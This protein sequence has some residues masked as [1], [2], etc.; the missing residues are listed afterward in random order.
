M[1]EFASARESLETAVK[2]DN[3]RPGF[4]QFLAQACLRLE[5]RT[6]ARA[7]LEELLRLTPPNYTL[8]IHVS[9]GTLCVDLED[10]TCAQRALAA[11]RRLKPD[12]GGVKQLEQH[13]EQRK[14]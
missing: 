14:P 8:P 11:A 1:G 7:A 4:H 9:L 13:F 5:D 10:W 2:L 12:H 3:S 6:G